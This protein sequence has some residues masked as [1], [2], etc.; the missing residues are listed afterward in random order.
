L[1]SPEVEVKKPAYFSTEVRDPSFNPFETKSK[2]EGYKEL[3]KCS[4]VL[5]KIN[6]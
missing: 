4:L 2:K 3:V 6:T 5:G 1:R